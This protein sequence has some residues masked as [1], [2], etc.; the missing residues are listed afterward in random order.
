MSKKT[1]M[2][3]KVN[4]IRSMALSDIPASIN[5][6]EGSFDDYKSRRIAL[7]LSIIQVLIGAEMP[8]RKDDGGEWKLKFNSRLPDRSE[9]ADIIDI[10]DTFVNEIENPYLNSFANNTVSTENDMNIPPRDGFSPDT[11]RAVPKI[12]KINAKKLKNYIFGYDSKD[13]ISRVYLNASDCI[14]VSA[15]GEELRKKTN[16]N[17]MLIVGGIALLITGGTVAAICIRNYN[18]KAEREIDGMID[19][20]VESD[21]IPTMDMSE[22]TDDVPTVTID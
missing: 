7:N 15:L 14:K 13:A 3:E 8:D 18:K 4:Q 5:R 22:D 12:E 11:V 20:S 10:V 9:L 16:R 2:K 17:K 1:T 6:P 21:N 19:L